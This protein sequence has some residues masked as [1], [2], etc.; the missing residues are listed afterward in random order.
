MSGHLF[1]DSGLGQTAEGHL[2]QGG[3]LTRSTGVRQRSVEVP[4]TVVLEWGQE[5][6]SSG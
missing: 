2:A 5:L 1:N 6:L 4:R 3:A